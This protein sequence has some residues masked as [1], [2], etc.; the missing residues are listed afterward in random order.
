M[1]AN[2]ILLHSE[3]VCASQ[4]LG[5]LSWL[6]WLVLVISILLGPA[7]AYLGVRVDTWY[8]GAFVMWFVFVAGYVKLISQDKRQKTLLSLRAQ[9]GQATDRKRDLADIESYYTLTRDPMDHTCLDDQ[10]WLDMNMDQL[11]AAIDRTHTSPGQSMLYKILRTPQSSD[12]TLKQRNTVVRLFMNQQDLREKVQLDLM[13]LGR[14]REPGITSLIWGDIPQ[15]T[16]FRHLYS[17][18]AL[19]A[20]TGL[21]L[22]YRFLGWSSL[23]LV[24]L[25]L[26]LINMLVTYR[27]RLQLMCHLT[28]I[29]YLGDMI[30]I[31]KSLA[32][33]KCVELS[34]YKQAM[35]AIVPLVQSIDSKTVFLKPENSVSSD[36][37]VL[38]YG[39]LNTYF[40]QEVRTFYAVLD[41]L[42]AHQKELQ[43]LYSLIGELDALM[44]VASYRHGLGDALSEP[45][46]LQEEVLDAEDLRHPMIP[47]SVPNSIC[48]R[49]RGVTVTGSNMAGKT[50]FLRTLGINAILAQTLYVTLS[51][52]YKA[53]AFRIISSLNERDDLLAGKSYYL[54][55]AE[56]LLRMVRA[57]E[58][59]HPVLCL[60]DEPLV[61]TNSSERIAASLEILRYLVKH[62]AIV[63]VSMHDLEL[64]HTLEPDYES[65]HFS[66][67]VDTQGLTFDYRLR[68]GIASTS[69]AI[70]LLAYL[71]YPKEIVDRATKIAD[72]R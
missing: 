46:L 18:L 9:W 14:Q 71:K 57:S 6:R 3:L 61:G 36:L 17:A 35:E 20:L 16:P 59:D 2:W 15:S 49:T 69:N 39:H 32:T 28:S 55:E 41:K 21:V 63:F 10:T 67:D 68:Q 44:A 30:R 58:R 40:L 7:I 45:T 1:K 22:G 72:G 38:V 48:L 34:R 8:F 13:R 29:R 64:A 50:T 65:H 70:K 33:A 37:G 5:E 47:D 42:R 53:K 24:V 60:I 66:D 31:A 12:E 27:I 23:L 26:Y 19:V 52:S 62:N 4:K 54:V 25:P 43:T 51:T 11:Y 56:N